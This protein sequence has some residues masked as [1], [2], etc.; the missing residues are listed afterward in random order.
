MSSH[1]DYFDTRVLAKHTLEKIHARHGGH[2]QVNKDDAGSN[3]F[4]CFQAFLGI[5]RRMNFQPGVGQSV[6]DQSQCCC[7]I[8]DRQ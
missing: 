8:V 4:E 3:A 7:I 6:L 1:E 2:H 5:G